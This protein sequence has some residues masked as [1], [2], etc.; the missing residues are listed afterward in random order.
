MSLNVVPYSHSPH[1]E[2]CASFQDT[3]ATRQNNEW[4]ADSG[5]VG[6]STR[7]AGVVQV[8]VYCGLASILLKVEYLSLSLLK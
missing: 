2:I 1:K 3:K 6:K 8:E 5:M 4:V 7:I